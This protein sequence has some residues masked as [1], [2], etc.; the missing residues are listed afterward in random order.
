MFV[1]YQKVSFRERKKERK[2]GVCENGRDMIDCNFYRLLIVENKQ[3]EINPALFR[4]IFFSLSWKRFD[5]GTPYAKRKIMQ[6][7]H[8]MKAN[9]FMQCLEFVFAVFVSCEQK[10]ESLLFDC[11]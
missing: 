2:N 4:L 10:I 7:I 9:I 1:A 5:G 11:L 6:G 3:L 8:R